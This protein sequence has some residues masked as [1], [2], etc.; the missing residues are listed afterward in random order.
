MF[1]SLLFR[2]LSQTPASRNRGQEGERLAESHLIK[3]KG[4]RLIARNWRN[5]ADKRE[6]IDLVMRDGEILV[7]VEVKTRRAGALVSG[8][9]AVDE[10]KRR[11]LRRAIRAYLRGL[12]ETPRTY[13]FDVVEVALP[14]EAEEG[15]PEIRHFERVQLGI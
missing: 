6:E 5:P 13:R 4:F 12:P 2:W 11:V 1:R 9:H 3:S 7:F 15:S 14:G 10:R 8:F